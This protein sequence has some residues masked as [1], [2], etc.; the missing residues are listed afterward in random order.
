MERDGTG[1]EP[2]LHKRLFVVAGFLLLLQTQGEDEQDD[3]DKSD[4]DALSQAGKP[5]RGLLLAVRHAAL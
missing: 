4:I 2:T 1:P 5:A 3:E